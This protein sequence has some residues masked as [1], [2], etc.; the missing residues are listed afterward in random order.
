[1]ECRDPAGNALDQMLAVIVRVEGKL[2]LDDRLQP[3]QIRAIQ[4]SDLDNFH[5]APPAVAPDSFRTI[6]RDFTRSAWTL[7]TLGKRGI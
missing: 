2:E 1:M 4:I 3:K 5:A 6:V 7:L